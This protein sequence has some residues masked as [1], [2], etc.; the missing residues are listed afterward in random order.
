MRYLAKFLITALA[1]LGVSYFLPGFSVSGFWS[2]LAVAFILGL[3]NILVRPIL[4]ILTFPITLLTLGLFSL[5]ING[6]LLWFV[7]S[8]VEGFA[9]SSFWAALLGAA[10]ISFVGWVADRILD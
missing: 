5:V 3:L 9:V 1:L 10:I 8:F 6:A 2:A 4:L 7:A